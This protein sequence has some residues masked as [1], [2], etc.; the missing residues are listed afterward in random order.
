MVTMNYY[1]E[2]ITL[3]TADKTAADL[4]V[5]NDVPGLLTAKNAAIGIKTTNFGLRET[6][7]TSSSA[8]VGAAAFNS[9]ATYK[10]AS[11]GAT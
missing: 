3:W 5:T 2:Y 8:A 6:L 1:Q 9:Y 10:A 4:A 11:Y 7:M